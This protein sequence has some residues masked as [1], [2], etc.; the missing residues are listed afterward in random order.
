MTEA[1]G[2]MSFKDALA[3]FLQQAEVVRWYWN[4]FFAVAL[5]LIGL[6][7]GVKARPVSKRALPIVLLGF[8]V[9]AAGNLSAID[10]TQYQRAALRELALSKAVT[11][12]ERNA[13]MAMDVPPRLHYVAFHIVCDILVCIAIIWVNPESRRAAHAQQTDKADK[14]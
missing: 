12:Q 1:L 9:F 6:L 2:G 4:F 14:A 8:V 7:A 10:A 13:T 3:M 11:S 5:G